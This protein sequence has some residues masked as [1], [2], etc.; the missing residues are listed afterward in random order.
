LSKCACCVLINLHIYLYRFCEADLMSY[1][2]PYRSKAIFAFQIID[3]KE[4]CF[5]GM[6]VQEYGSSCPPPNSRQIYIAYL[7]SVKY[8]EPRNLRTAV[9]QEILLGYMEY[10]KS[11]GFMKVNIW[12]CP[13][14]RNNEYI[15][16]CHPLEQKFPNGK[17]LQEWYKCLLDK[18]IM[19]NIIVDYR[20]IYKHIQDS[21][22]TSVTELPYFEGDWLPE[23]LENLIKKL[24]KGI[25]KSTTDASVTNSP[26]LAHTIQNNE[27]RVNVTVSQDIISGKELFE[28]A[29]LY[30]KNH[31]E[32]LSMMSKG[33]C[34][35]NES[36]KIHYTRK[37]VNG[38]GRAIQT[39]SY[40]RKH[41][42][43]HRDSE[44][45]NVITQKDYI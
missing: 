45:T 37:S 15:F 39:W 3:N 20:E 1:K 24:K 27:Q 42:R 38:A 25:Q 29:L 10:A 21:C 43:D 30:I 18:G 40:G 11:L 2:F 22:F 35:D 17:M 7:D 6:F 32:V 9:Y 31:R 41:S 23:M 44:L 14:N 4:I 5:F 36:S 13:S 34:A 8:F 16:Y 26:S 12:A 33:K 28:N 19:E